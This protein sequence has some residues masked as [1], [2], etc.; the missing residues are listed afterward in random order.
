MYKIGCSDR[1]V[2]WLR[3]YLYRTQIVNVNTKKSSEISIRSRI[4]QGTVLGPLIFIF[5]INDIIKSISNCNV[6]IF[7]DDCILYCVGNNFEPMFRKIQG[8]LNIF[9][10]WCSLN[11]LKINSGKT[12]AM[13]V[14]TKSRLNN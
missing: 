5:Y 11:S 2:A 6:S 4:A 12:K 3:S 1:V 10:E 8:D 7:A 9:S 13:I 14:S